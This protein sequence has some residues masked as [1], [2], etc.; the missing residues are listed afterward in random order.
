M[1]PFYL[2]QRAKKQTTCTSVSDGYW[3]TSRGSLSIPSSWDCGR[4]VY[5]CCLLLCLPLCLCLLSCLLLVIF[6]PWIESTVTS[7]HT[8]VL[9][10][11][12]LHAVCHVTSMWLS[13]DLDRL[14]IS[15]LRPVHCAG[16]SGDGEGRIAQSCTWLQR[17]PT[18]TE[19][20]LTL[21]LSTHFQQAWTSNFK[22]ECGNII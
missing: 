8:L 19:K 10:H 5:C 12:C 20:I 1:R 7:L 4:S 11:V 2:P 15:W 9:Q 16:D 6:S 17:H 3:S 14:P 21:T 18:G 13:G 22:S